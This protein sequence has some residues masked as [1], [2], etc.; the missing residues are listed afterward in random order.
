MHDA[1]IAEK[2]V[3]TIRNSGLSIYDPIEIGDPNLWIPTQELELLLQR[4]LQGISLDQLPLRTRSKE[5]KKLV[6]TALGYPV[7]PRFRRTRPR[8]PGQRFDTYVQKSYNLQIWNEDIDPS[9]RYVLIHLDKDNKIQRVR[10]VTG[11]ALA[12]L[13]TTG[14]LTQKYQA[15]CI[16]QSTTELV[17]DED[18]D[19]VRPIVSS[20]PRFSMHTVPTD[21]PRPGVLYSIRA[22][23]ERPAK[24]VGVKFQDVGRDQ[25]RNRGWIVHKLVCNVLGYIKYEEH[26]QFPDIP[27]QLLEVKLQTSPTIDLGLV[28]PD[29]RDPIG[30]RNIEGRQLRYCDVR[31]AVFYGNIEHGEVTLTHVI[32]TTGEAFFD[33]FPQFGGKVL[34]KKLQIHLPRHF[35]D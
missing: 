8:F 26:G 7:P 35:F 31:Y 11:S 21:N 4:K 27:H 32:L 33:R 12:R 9:R 2:F 13:D 20:S 17:V 24:L 10:V 5:V 14:T 28:R 29:S 18:T 15:R 25:E 23:M 16:P 22:L 1:Q 19:V 34:N 3:E 30:M 6:C